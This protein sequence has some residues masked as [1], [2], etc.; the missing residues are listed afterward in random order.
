MLNTILKKTIKNKIKRK[1]A[2]KNKQEKK[3]FGRG[4]ISADDLNFLLERKHDWSYTSSH[5]I[6]ENLK[7]VSRGSFV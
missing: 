4:F 2:E 7:C 5:L 6:K 1:S 3:I